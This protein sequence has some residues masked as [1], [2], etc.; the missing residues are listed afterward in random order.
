MTEQTLYICP[1][2]DVCR[3]ANCAHRVQHAHVVTCDA[4]CDTPTEECGACIPV[5][6]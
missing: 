4:P 6:K 5:E 2:A 1:L 3:V